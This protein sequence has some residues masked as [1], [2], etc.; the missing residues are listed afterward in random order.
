MCKSNK[1][2]HLQKVAAIHEYNKIYFIVQ[3]GVTKV[4]LVSPSPQQGKRQFVQRDQVFFLL[5]VTCCSLH[6]NKNYSSFSGGSSLRIIL[7]DF[8]LLSS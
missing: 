8:H 5:L 6:L 2:L 4:I 3:I 1:S 7:G